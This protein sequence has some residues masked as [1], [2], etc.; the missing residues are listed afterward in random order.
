VKSR[1]SS[2]FFLKTVMIFVLILTGPAGIH[3][4]VRAEPWTPPIGIPVPPFGIIES[5]ATY[6]GQLYDYDNNGTPEGAYKDAGNGPY[7]H[8]V[9][10]SAP[11]C[12]DGSNNSNSGTPALPRCTIPGRDGAP[13]KA[14]SVVEVHGKYDYE[15]T[16]PADLHFAG[17]AAKPVFIRGASAANRP[18][19]TG[20]FDVVGSSYTIVENILFSDRDGDLSDGPCGSFGVTDKNGQRYDSDHIVLRHSEV[21][22]NLNCGGTGVGGYSGTTILSN[23]VLWDNRIHDNGDVNA[24]FD[25]DVHGTGVGTGAQNV[26]ILDSEYYRNSGD[27]VQI[28]GSPTAT[29]HLYLGRNISHHN[30]QTGLWTKNASDVIFSENK[31]YGHRAGNSSGGGGMGFQYDPRRVWFLFNEAYDNVQGMTHGSADDGSRSDIYFIGNILHDNLFCGMQLNGWVEGEYVIGNTFYNNPIG[32]E[33]GYHRIGL[34]ISN[35]IFSNNPT[36]ISFTEYGSGAASNLRHCLF[37]SPVKIV[38]DDVVRNIA[39]MQSI[40]ECLGCQS[41]DPLFVNALAADFNLQRGSP[42]I[43]MGALEAAY[44]TYQQLYGIDIRRDKAG[45][46]RPQGAG[47][48]VGAYEYPTSPGTTPPAGP[49]GLRLE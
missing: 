47:W 2:A 5:H 35:N 31:V 7:T 15:H 24:S 49:K 48:D 42:G 34:E 14:G 20:S 27:G 1:K 29:H 13:L 39:S 12:T 21:S 23:I 33:N 45:R 16:S 28:N 9:D 41:G 18:S 17:T 4:S 26:W 38:W 25:Q 11:N 6:Q 8:Y 19:L 40:G 44:A 46:T 22:G 37:E 36:A 32:L 43:D 3:Q 30:K 10:R